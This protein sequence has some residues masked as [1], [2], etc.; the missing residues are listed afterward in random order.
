MDI[1]KEIK[2][3][4]SHSEV[5]FISPKE[6]ASL[7]GDLFVADENTAPF[8]TPEQREKALILPP[9]E[10]AKT[11]PNVEKIL[12]LAL[13]KKLDR[14]SVMVGVG[15]G[16][17]CDM[18]AF[19]ASLYMRGC[20]VELVPTTLLAMVD[21]AMGGKTGVDYGN[22]KNMVGSFY[23]ARRVLINPEFLNTLSQREFLCGLAEVIKTALLADRTLLEILEKR[24]DEVL[25]RDP[26]LVKELIT[27][28]ILVKSRI[29][30]EDLREGG[31]RA[32]LNLGHT[33]GHALETVS[34]FSTISHGEAVAWGISKAALAALKVG[35]IE[36]EYHDR[37]INLLKSYDYNLEFEF[38]VDSLI[39]AMGHDKKIRAGEKRFIL[40]T[41][42]GKHNITP[43]KPE[44]V[45]EVLEA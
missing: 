3:A 4:S 6:F 28:C 8:L 45:R 33:F 14:S 25:K 9:G 24:K 19:A 12:F 30:Q 17:I 18:T 36:Q 16:V 22:Y 26:M 1:V 40:T 15:G 44:L 5:G 11:F 39:D 42:V 38:P 31:I 20:Q 35:Q 2:F 21:A 32:C 37:V 27:H 34:G 43:L 29:V 23:P 7:K 13:E 10:E 41:G